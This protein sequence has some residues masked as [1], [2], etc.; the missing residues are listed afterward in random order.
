MKLFSFIKTVK[1]LFLKGF[2][3]LLPFI[4][5]FTLF[6]FIFSIIA[7]WLEPLRILWIPFEKALPT[8]LIDFLKQ[9]ELLLLIGLIIGIGYLTRTKILKLFMFYF[10]KILTTI[11]FIKAVYP[12]IKQLIHAFSAHDQS[13]FNT[14]VLVQFPTP[15]I[16]SIG[17]LTKTVP[18]QM[19]H[20]DSKQYI[21]IYIPMTPNPTHGFFVMVPEGEYIVTDLTRQEATSLIISGGILQ[22]ERYCTTKV[23]E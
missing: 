19:L 20:K 10:E 2:I 6:K 12:G 1:N 4:I 16:Y 17:F 14:V 7:H 22:P 9:F 3:F 21:N 18:C 8:N 15:G 11:P 13:S 5:T 23:K